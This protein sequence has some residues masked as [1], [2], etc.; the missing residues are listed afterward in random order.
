VSLITSRTRRSPRPF[1]LRSRHGDRRLRQQ[2]A[3]HD[4]STSVERQLELDVDAILTPIVT[5]SSKHEAVRVR[6]NVV[7][8]DFGHG[9]LRLGLEIRLAGAASRTCVQFTTLRS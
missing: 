5:L 1:G 9:N 4:P 7:D 2:L 3:E 8:R 6:A